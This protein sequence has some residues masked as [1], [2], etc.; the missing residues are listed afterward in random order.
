M[1]RTE[2]WEAIVLKTYDIGE[3]DR[4]CVLFTRERGRIAVRAAGVRKVKSRMGGSLLPFRR[5]LIDVK[6][7][8]T[9]WIA[10][11]VRVRGEGESVIHP[12]AFVA[13][14]EGI[15]VLLHLT[16]DMEPHPAVFETTAAFLRACTENVPHASLAYTLR[17]LHLLGF[18]PGPEEM[19]M[20]FTLGEAEREFLEATREGYMLRKSTIQNPS[21]LERV[22]DRFLK[23]QLVG[24]LK[25]PRVVMAMKNSK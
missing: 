5:V 21:M 19:G 6:E 22:R 8:A 7:S 9:G 4:Y 3:A 15:E 1:P 24:P 18:L 13:S 10:A 12:H 23:D 20:F 25:A 16:Q 2:T 14:A 17:L 11:G